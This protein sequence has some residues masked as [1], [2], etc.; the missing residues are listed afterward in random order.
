MSVLEAQG[1]RSRVVERWQRPFELPILAELTEDTPAA[2]AVAFEIVKSIEG[3]WQR[4]E[5][6]ADSAA[7]QAYSGSRCSSGERKLV[8]EG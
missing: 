2:L 7:A 4:A 5:G 3:L 1:E 6:L 8:L